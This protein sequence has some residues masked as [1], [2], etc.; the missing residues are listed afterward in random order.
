VAGRPE[1]IKIGPW[2]QFTVEQAREEADS[3]NGTIADGINPNDARRQRREAPTLGEAFEEYISL[4]T[5]GKQKRP[6]APKTIEDYRWIFKKHLATW[7]HRRLSDISRSDI[8]R[9]HNE[10]GTGIG[11][12]IANRT[13]ALLKSVLNLGMDRGW[14]EAN[15]AARMHAF[16]ETPRERYLAAGEL[17]AFW[18]AIEAEGAADFFKLLLLTGVRKSNALSARWEQ[19]DLDAAVW[20][21]PRT[22]G[23]K[24]LELP[25]AP[26]AVE[27][28]LARRKRVH[29]EWVFP[30]A[31]GNGPMP[32]PKHAWDR[33]RTAAG[34]P[35]IRIHDLRR[36]L[37]SWQASGGSSL[38]VIGKSLGH[39]SL[40]ATQIYS[41]VS[42]D[43]VRE[44]VTAATAAILAAAKP[45]EK[46]KRGRKRKGARNG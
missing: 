15:P 8:E 3:L 30:S 37:G 23:G 26:A 43:A 4:P 10:I 16:E 5:R 33:V 13:L 18:K 24:P 44:S 20:K 41:R 29:G 35:D 36:S 22:K 12:T 11:T 32:N 2:P 27:L 1:R 31:S 6:R 19:F 21:I 39:T 17:P 42:Q 28:L 34:L 14:I 40:Q 25:L 46:P 38:P 7:T 9:L 45:P